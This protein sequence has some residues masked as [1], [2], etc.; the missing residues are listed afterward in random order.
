[1]LSLNDEANPVYPAL[2]I[3]YYFANTLLFEDF[4]DSRNAGIIISQ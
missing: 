2:V 1:M 4:Q 3:D